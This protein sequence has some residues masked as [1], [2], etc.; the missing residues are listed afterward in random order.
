M[1]SDLQIV[2][3]W[4]AIRRLADAP[5]PGLTIQQLADEAA[6]SIKT[7]RRDINQLKDVGFPVVE[8]D[9]EYGR[10]YWHDVLGF[11]GANVP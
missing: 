7:I 8:S 9:G 1:S 3:Q 10:K 2:R 4:L 11:G 6:L 5:P